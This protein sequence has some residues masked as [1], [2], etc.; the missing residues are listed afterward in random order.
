[1]SEPSAGPV[2]FGIN[3]N[4]QHKGE[5]FMTRRGRACP[6]LTRQHLEAFIE[7]ELDGDVGDTEQAGQ[8]PAVECARALFSVDP[9]QGVPRVPVPHVAVFGVLGHEARLDHPEWVGQ[10]GAARA[11][12]HGRDDVSDRIIGTWRWVEA[13]ASAD[14]PSPL[15]SAIARGTCVCKGCVCGVGED[16]S[17]GSDGPLGQFFVFRFIR[18]KGRTPRTEGSSEV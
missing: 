8:H 3:A 7:W 11:G 5:F 6:K 10:D 14:D 18:P 4:R 13:R 16:T 17:A 15:L 12:R 1:M 2:S 9:D